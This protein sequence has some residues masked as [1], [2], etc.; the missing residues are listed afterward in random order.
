MPFIIK[1][2]KSNDEK[3]KTAQKKE[4]EKIK[5]YIKNK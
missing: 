4:R 3:I 2:L 1:N 5:P